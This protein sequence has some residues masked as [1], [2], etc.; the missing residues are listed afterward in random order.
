M[1][2]YCKTCGAKMED[3]DLFCDSCGQAYQEETTFG[4]LE[5]KINACQK[6]EE[7]DEIS[8]KIQT[9]Y[10]DPNDRKYLSN[11]LNKA[12]RRIA[13]AKDSEVASQA[14]QFI[15]ECD[16]IDKAIT[17]HKMI[18][19]TN[20]TEREKYRLKRLLKVHIT[21][22]Q[23]EL[24]ERGKKLDAEDRSTNFGGF[25]AF[26]L[27]TIMSYL[28]YR[29]VPI[30]WI[31]VIGKWSMYI[32]AAFALISIICLI[33]SLI[34]WQTASKEQKDASL[35]FVSLKNNELYFDP[36]EYVICDSDIK[37]LRPEQVRN[38]DIDWK[39]KACME[40][41]ARHGE[42]FNEDEELG[43][44]FSTKSWYNSCPARD[45]KD[46]DLNKYEIAN[47]NLLRDNN[48]EYMMKYVE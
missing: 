13:D 23:K 16:S 27:L 33:Y 26:L 11:V 3:D 8:E 10:D 24:I 37:Y 18:M 41:L 15:N 36:R 20:I 21:E 2:K 6:Y 42:K 47:Y 12:Y 25:I 17:L 5:N 39:Q 4:E 32:C 40:I 30:K 31:A 7:L 44:Y 14:E 38:K 46:A 9:E 45:V 48:P 19:K 1:A 43:K 34:K 28:V 29:F 22:Q 35:K